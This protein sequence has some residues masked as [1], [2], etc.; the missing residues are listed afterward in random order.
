M[1]SWD[2]IMKDID[3]TLNQLEPELT[4]DSVTEKEIDDILSDIPESEEIDVDNIISRISEPDE[5]ITMEE[6]NKFLSDV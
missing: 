5:S 4:F 3:E 6:I 1:T 2:R